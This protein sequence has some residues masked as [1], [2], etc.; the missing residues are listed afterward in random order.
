[1]LLV[2]YL[3]R[4]I[5]RRTAHEIRLSEERNKLAATSVEL[6]ASKERAEAASRAKSSFLANMSHELRTPLNAVIGFAQLIDG[7][8][9][10]PLGSPRYAEYARDIANAGSHLLGLIG[11]I[12]D[13]AKIEA[14]KFTLDE[15]AVD[16]AEI[17]ACG[18]AHTR[19]TAAE[20]NVVVRAAIP[21]SLPQIQADPLR[22]SQVVINLLS[23]AVRFTA[24]GG[25]ILIAAERESDGE[26]AVAVSDTG[27]GMTDE[28]IAVALAPFGQVESSLART[29]GGTGLGLPLARRLVELHGGTLEVDSAPGTGT[30]VRLRLPASRVIP[31]QHV[32]LTAA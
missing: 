32:E 9:F 11:D 20:R 6:L 8:K 13:L 21:K 27:I 12:L 4:E 3:I 26:I 28:E 19:S 31:E 25:G 18:I 5:G 30:T 15:S 1:V 16:I 7:Q 2:V 22:L 24:E 29:H 14:G 10:G 17:V 23:N